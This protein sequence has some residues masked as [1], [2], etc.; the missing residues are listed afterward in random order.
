MFNFLKKKTPKE[1]LEKQYRELLAKA[2]KLSNVDRMK[3]DA[4]TAEAEE[5]WKQIEALTQ[6]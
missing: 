3:S 4:T 2:H 5:V 6:E 1:K